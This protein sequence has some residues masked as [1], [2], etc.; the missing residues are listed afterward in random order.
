LEAASAG[1]TAD[2]AVTFKAPTS[3]VFYIQVNGWYSG[4]NY[5]L[6]VKKI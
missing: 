3:G 5:T 6:T 2:E 4:G 1:R